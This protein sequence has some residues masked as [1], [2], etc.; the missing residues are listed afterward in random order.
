VAP[1]VGSVEKDP[2]FQRR[3]I[4]GLGMWQRPDF[5]VA[6]VGQRTLAV[7]APLEV[8]ELVRVRLGIKQDLKITGTLLDEFQALE[9]DTAIRL[10][11]NDPPS[12]DHFFTPIFTPELLAQAQIFGLGLKLENPVKAR[13]IL[14][15]KS[16]KAAEELAQQVRENPQRWLRLQDSELLLFAQPPDVTT[17]GASLEIRCSVPDNSARLLLQRVAKTS[18]APSIAG[19]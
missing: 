15:M 7:G 13:L 14:R 8:E 2:S 6:R 1:V 17:Q 5:A 11:S 12:L 16:S 10:I 3:A 9:Q 18:P 19:Q 4:N